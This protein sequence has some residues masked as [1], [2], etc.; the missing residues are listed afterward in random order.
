MIRMVML[1]VVICAMSTIK[2]KICCH[3]MLK[4]QILSWNPDVQYGSLRLNA[5]VPVLPFSGKNGVCEHIKYI[6]YF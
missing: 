5:S 6:V 1:G 4:Y 2:S 3:V